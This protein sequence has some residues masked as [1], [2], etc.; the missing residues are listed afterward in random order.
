MGG[1]WAE[2]TESVKGSIE[3]GKYAD[4]V[5]LDR[6]PLETPVEELTSIAIE[7]AFVN[8]QQVQSRN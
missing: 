1:A 3:T 7:S 6:N 8:G 2:G 5:V 4:F